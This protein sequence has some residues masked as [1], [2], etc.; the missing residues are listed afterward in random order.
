ML[1]S[2]VHQES[3]S[4]GFK[5]GLLF[6]TLSIEPIPELEMGPNRPKFLEVTK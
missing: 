1:K 3:G 4:F 5:A 6:D 2:V